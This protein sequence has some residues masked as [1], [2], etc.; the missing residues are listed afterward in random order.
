VRERVDS[1]METRSRM[2]L[3]LAG[4]PEPEV[5]PTI[6]AD[7]GFTVRKYDLCYWRSR[8]LIEY[9]G[10]QHVE[11]VQQWEEDVDR[12]A[13]IEDDSW[14]SIVLIAKHIYRT[15]GETLERIHRI[16]LE[17]GE[18]GVPARLADRWRRYFPERP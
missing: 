11:R 10:R 18:P 9:D 15:P 16:L 4:L 2:L 7:D 14:R 13:G 6:L 5:N 1:A 17:R 12:R 8:T 3:V